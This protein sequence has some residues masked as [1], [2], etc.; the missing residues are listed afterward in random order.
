MKTVDEEEKLGAQVRETPGESNRISIVC[1]CGD[2]A[3]FSTKERARKSWKGSSLPV[4]SVGEASLRW[5]GW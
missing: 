3:S 1:R 4:G 2:Y 5:A